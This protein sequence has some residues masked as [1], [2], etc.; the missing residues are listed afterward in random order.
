MKIKSKFLIVISVI[1]A[2]LILF[3][4]TIVSAFS[5]M[6]NTDEKLKKV[7][8]NKGKSI[9]DKKITLNYL[10]LQYRHNLHC[11]QHGTDLFSS[12]NV[13]YTIADYVEINGKEAKLYT[14]SKSSPKIIKNNYNAQVAY[15]LGQGQGYGWNNTGTEEQ[16]AFWKISNNWTNNLFRKK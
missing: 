12:T 2:V 8:E 15:I 14:S 10:D 1:F 16:V 5:P 3:T 9:I 4:A 13:E 6:Y 7:F 11:I